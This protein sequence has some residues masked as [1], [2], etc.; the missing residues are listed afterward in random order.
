MTRILLATEPAVIQK[1]GSAEQLRVKLLLRHI[2][3]VSARAEGLLFD[4]RTAGAPPRYELQ[5]ITCPLLAVSAKDD[6]YGTSA[7]AEYT[8]AEVPNGRA[9]IYETGGHI[10]AGH[11][12]DVWREI[13]SFLSSAAELR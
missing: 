7:S 10:L 8:A 13:A 9:L 5:K 11:N 3:P 1:L 12:Q 4:M 2:L 6:L